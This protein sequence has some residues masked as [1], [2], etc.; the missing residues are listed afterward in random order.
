MSTIAITLTNLASVDFL[1]QHQ[2]REISIFLV[3]K[4]KTREREK[5]LFLAH[6][7]PPR[8]RRRRLI[9]KSAQD[10]KTT[11]LRAKSVHYLLAYMLNT[12]EHDLS[13]TDK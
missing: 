3:K 9:E 12:N 4:K 1:F 8:R 10:D 2:P 6:A 13:F 7:R 11:S 5:E